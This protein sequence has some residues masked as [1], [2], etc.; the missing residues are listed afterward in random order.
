LQFALVLGGE[1]RGVARLIVDLLAR[2][3]VPLTAAQAEMILECV[4]G[5]L[6]KT[7]WERALTA[8]S[9]QELMGSASP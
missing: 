1:R 3:G 8:D 6:L 2:R 4:D 9:T 5:D 7:W